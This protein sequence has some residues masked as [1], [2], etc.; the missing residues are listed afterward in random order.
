LE[1]AEMEKW[2]RTLCFFS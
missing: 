1:E 2:R